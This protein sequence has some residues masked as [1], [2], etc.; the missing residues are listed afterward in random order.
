MNCTTERGRGVEFEL[1]DSFLNR[2]RPAMSDQN[3]LYD[4]RRQDWEA[5]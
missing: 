2:G 5:C 3:Q 1:N 4:E